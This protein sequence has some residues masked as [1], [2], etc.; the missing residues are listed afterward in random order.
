MYCHACPSPPAECCTQAEIV[1][2]CQSGAASAAGENVVVSAST[3][4]CIQATLH[5]CCCSSN[6]PEGINVHIGEGAFVVRAVTYSLDGVGGSCHTCGVKPHLLM[7][8]LRAAS[9]A[10]SVP[11][12]A[13]SSRSTAF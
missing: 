9:L 7:R 4:V 2:S 6:E 10:A 8:I 5:S 12:P 3:R 11:V 1:D 13:D